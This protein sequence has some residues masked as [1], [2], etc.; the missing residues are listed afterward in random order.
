MDISVIRKKLF[1]RDR[2]S[3]EFSRSFFY[4]NIKFLRY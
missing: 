1:L 4:A 3:V 2:T